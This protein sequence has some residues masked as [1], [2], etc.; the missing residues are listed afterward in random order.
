MA[1]IRGARPDADGCKASTVRARSIHFS[2]SRRRSGPSSPALKAHAPRLPTCTGHLLIPLIDFLASKGIHEDELEES[3]LTI[4]F[5]TNMID[6][7]MDICKDSA[8]VPAAMSIRVARRSC[9][10]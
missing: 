4:L 2:L 5:K 10:R 8:P 3:K 9:R 6:L 7:A 1:S